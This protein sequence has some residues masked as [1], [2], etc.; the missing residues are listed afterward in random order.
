MGA[1][2]AKRGIESA[3]QMQGSW[4]EVNAASQLQVTAMQATALKSEA[5]ALLQAGEYSAAG[6]KF[7]EA[8]SAYEKSG[9]QAGVRSSGPC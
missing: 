7:T 5:Q 3:Q 1:A 8:K 9:N 6:K 2:T 4:S